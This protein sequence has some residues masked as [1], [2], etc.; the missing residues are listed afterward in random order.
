MD[1]FEIKAFDGVMFIIQDLEPGR[2]RS[3]GKTCMAGAL[4]RLVVI[5]MQ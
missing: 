2:V 1:R 3:T 5:F 4:L